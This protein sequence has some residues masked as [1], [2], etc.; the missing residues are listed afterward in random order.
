MEGSSSDTNVDVTQFNLLKSK[1]ENNEKSLTTTNETLS[2]LKTKITTTSD[3]ITQLEKDITDKETNL[4]NKISTTNSSISSLNEKVNSNQKSLNDKASKT[5]L[6]NKA[7]KKHTHN[8][9]DITDLE[10]TLDGKANKNDVITKTDLNSKADKIDLNKKANLSHTHK[11]SDITNLQTTLDDKANKSDVITKVDLNSKAD[12]IDLDKKADKTEVVTKTGVQL[13]IS[14]KANKEHT[15]SI[16]DIDNLRTE[17]DDN[18]N[19]I[20]IVNNRLQS[21]DKIF[22]NLNNKIDGKADKSEVVSKYDLSLKAD[23]EHTHNISDI[24]NLQGNINSIKAN[25]S[26]ISKL[27]NE[28]DNKINKYELVTETDKLKDKIKSLENIV[29]IDNEKIYWLME[30]KDKEFSRGG[31]SMNKT[32]NLYVD[33]GDY[34]YVVDNSYSP[35]ITYKKINDIKSYSEYILLVEDS[36]ETGGYTVVKSFTQTFGNSIYCGRI[37]SISFTSQYIVRVEKIESLEE[38]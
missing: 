5:D 6:D 35:K 11:I 12:K 8:I 38:R 3:K 32:L 25:T 34:V 29:F 26:S 13:L 27:T 36:N 10:T 37:E 28:L 33:S 14:N 16:D 24:T 30:L 17:L 9:S 15:H 18:K 23:K 4:E 20:T 22:E 1:V 7:D 21:K 31:F 2:T 19:K